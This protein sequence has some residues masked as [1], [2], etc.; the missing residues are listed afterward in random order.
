MWDDPTSAIGR[1][2]SPG[3]RLVWSGQPLRGIRFRA[4]DVFLIPFSLVWCG[5][6]VFWEFMALGPVAQGGGPMALVFPLFGLPFIVVG[7]YFVFGRFVVDARVRE[8]TFYAITNERVLI[9]TGLFGRRTKSLNLRALS[10]I[11]LAER[12]DGSGTITFGPIYPFGPWFGATPWPGA[13]QYGP[14]A[15]DMIERAKEVYDILR[16]TQKSA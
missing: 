6:A 3:E 4:A 8:R 10:D 13:G 15:F 9:V 7:L 12:P 16:Q 1:E 14:P 2:L 11:S 5:F